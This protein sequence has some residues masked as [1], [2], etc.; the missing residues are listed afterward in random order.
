MRFKESILGIVLIVAEIF[1]DGWVFLLLRKNGSCPLLHLRG[2]K[3]FLQNTLLEG[4]QP[5]KD[6]WRVFLPQS[7]YGCY[8]L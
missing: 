6:A 4:S 2:W 3:T 5:E 7:T 8:L 1:V